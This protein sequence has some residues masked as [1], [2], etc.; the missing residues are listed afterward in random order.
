MEEQKV[1]LIMRE[2]GTHT[3]GFSYYEAETTV[4]GARNT[5]EEAADILDH[6]IRKYHGDDRPSEGIYNFEKR[7]NT[8]YIFRM[9]DGLSDHFW[10]KTQIIGR[11]GDCY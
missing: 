5:L 2:K 9:E 8:S 3:D 1:Y 7:R 11:G 4:L 6:V 10:I